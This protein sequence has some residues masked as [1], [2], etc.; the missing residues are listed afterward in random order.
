M[1][2]LYAN[3]EVEPTL[4]RSP[5]DPQHLVAAW[6]QD[7]WSDGGARALVSA[8]SLDGGATWTHTLHPMSRCG[9]AA[10]GSS[11]DFERTTDPWVDIGSDGVCT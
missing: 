2:V 9:G 3:A 4:A 5:S 6:Q 10:G 11:G 8:A 7:R 1:A